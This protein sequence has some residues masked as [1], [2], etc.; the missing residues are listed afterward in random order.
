W[1]LRR[2]HPACESEAPARTDLA[3]ADGFDAITVPGGRESQQ[4]SRL[5]FLA[6]LVVDAALEQMMHRRLRVGL[7]QR[8][9]FLQLSGALLFAL[10]AGLA[11]LVTHL[12]V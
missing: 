11:D 12:A 2:G 5:H 7:H 8:G 3:F 1:I 4:H 10:G 6:G 9:D